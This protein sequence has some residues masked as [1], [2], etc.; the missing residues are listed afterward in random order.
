MRQWSFYCYL[1]LF[2]GPT[3][4]RMVSSEAGFWALVSSCLGVF[5]MTLAMPPVWIRNVDVCSIS[6]WWPLHSPFSWLWQ[7][8]WEARVSQV[9]VSGIHSWRLSQTEPAPPSCPVIFYVCNPLCY[10]T[11]WLKCE[12]GFCFVQLN[13]VSHCCLKRETECKQIIPT[14]FAKC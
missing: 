10:I 6:Q 4:K 11:F 1:L 12:C 3:V 8:L 7:F 2:S 9:C 5:I 14:H 13:P